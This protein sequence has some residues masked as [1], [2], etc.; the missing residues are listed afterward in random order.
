MSDSAEQVATAMRGS[1]QREASREQDSGA[2]TLVSVRIPTT[3]VEALR[4]A[5]YAGGKTVAHHIRRGVQ[6]ELAELR[7][8]HEFVERVKEHQAVLDDLVAQLEN[9]PGAQSE[10]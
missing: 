2:T 6:R 4:L 1:E 8:D 10:D 5:A 3:D 9:D 7:S